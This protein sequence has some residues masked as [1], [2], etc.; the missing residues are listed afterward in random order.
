MVLSVSIVV[1]SFRKKVKN[2]RMSERY[3][4]FE[5]RNYRKSV[6]DTRKEE[7]VHMML[8]NDIEMTSS[9]IHIQKLK[10]NKIKITYVYG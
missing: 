5:R 2:A 8:I 9:L 4:S 10:N 6:R 1:D 7:G 3:I